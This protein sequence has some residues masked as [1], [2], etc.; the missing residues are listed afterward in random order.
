MSW[1]QVLIRADNHSGP[2]DGFYVSKREVWGKKLFI[3][4]TQKENSTHL[5]RIARYVCLLV[6]SFD[7]KYTHK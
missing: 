5:F 6:Y 3:F 1:E 4:V 2:D 7:T